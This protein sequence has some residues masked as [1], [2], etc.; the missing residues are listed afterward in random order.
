MNPGDKITYKGKEYVFVRETGC[1]CACNVRT[2][3]FRDAS[4]KM[5]S[6]GKEEFNED[7]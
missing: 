4:G 1:R 3:R 5:F 2:L 6:L 7:V